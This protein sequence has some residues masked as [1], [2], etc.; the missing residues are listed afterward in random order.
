MERAFHDEDLVI[1]ISGDT[2][3]VAPPLIVSEAEIGEIFEKVAHVIRA[4]WL[5]SILFHAGERPGG[6]AAAQRLWT[7]IPP[8]GRISTSGIGT[9]MV[10]ISAIFIAL[11]M[12]L[13]AASLGVV[14]FLRFG[15]SAVD[16]ALMAL[17]VLIV[18]AIYNAVVGGSAI[19]PR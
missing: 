12:M 17:G 18:L 10:R 6:L 9:R 4:R 8:G 13:I 1:R 15:F 2:L 16:S 11:F 7:L 19:A 5:S 3:A 14:L